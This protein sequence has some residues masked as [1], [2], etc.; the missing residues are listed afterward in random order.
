MKIAFSDC[1][2]GCSSADSFEE[3]ESPLHQR[4]GIAV[5]LRALRLPGAGAFLG[6][7]PSTVNRLGRGSLTMAPTPRKKAMAES[8]CQAA[9]PVS[10]LCRRPPKGSE[11]RADERHNRAVRREQPKDDGSQAERQG[12]ARTVFVTHKR[13]T[14]TDAHQVERRQ[15][16]CF[17]NLRCV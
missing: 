12:H 3:D 8:A 7:R 17:L 10:A 13:R 9:T 11:D 14:D 2:L 15:Q 6:A 5:R 16:N 4:L 1:R